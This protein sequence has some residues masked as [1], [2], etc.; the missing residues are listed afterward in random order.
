MGKKEGKKGAKNRGLFSIFGRKNKRKDT[1]QHEMVSQKRHR[2]RLNVIS[3]LLVQK[4]LTQC[5]FG[6]MSTILVFLLEN[7]SF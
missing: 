3:N 7:L 4:G 5:Q 6:E 2:A 1:T